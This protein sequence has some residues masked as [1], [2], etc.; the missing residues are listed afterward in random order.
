MLSGARILHPNAERLVSLEAAAAELRLSPFWLRQRMRARGI[1]EVWVQR[2]G[3]IRR[4]DLKALKESNQETEKRAR[5]MLSEHRAQQRQ[6][7]RGISRLTHK[8]H[9]DVMRRR[10]PELRRLNGGAS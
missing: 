3:Y 4:A 8:D 7:G 6:E 5:A 9:L 2:V 1:E 10:D